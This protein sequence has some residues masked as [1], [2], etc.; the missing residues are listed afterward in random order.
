MDR[1]QLTRAEAV[2]LLF[3]TG[4]TAER[5]LVDNRSKAKK[6]FPG[7]ARVIDSVTPQEADAAVYR[8]MDSLKP[9]LAK[10]NEELVN[11][12]RL[13]RERAAEREAKDLF[14]KSVTTLLKKLN[15]VGVL[16]G[17][18]RLACATARYPEADIRLN[19]LDKL[20]YFGRKMP[21]YPGAKSLKE[22]LAEKLG[23]RV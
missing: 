21:T 13:E 20:E 2:A 23:P 17:Q 6:T 15:D 9:Q 1:I 11:K 4:P 22:L 19:R 12:E 18:E 10:F 5:A 14:Y 7:F 3:L 16:T 8:L